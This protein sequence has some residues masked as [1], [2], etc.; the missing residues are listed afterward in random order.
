MEEDIGIVADHVGVEVG[1]VDDE[2]GQI[3]EQ[4]RGGHRHCE[5][6]G[7]QS[8][9]LA[10]RHEHRHQRHERGH[11]VDEHLLHGGKRHVGF[12]VAVTVS[13]LD[14]QVHQSQH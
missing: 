8:H 10:K 3:A 12:D 2:V 14:Y 7:A 11:H 6:T 13:Q 1:A 5:Q 9:V 4:E